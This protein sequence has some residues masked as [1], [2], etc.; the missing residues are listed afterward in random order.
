M[1]VGKNR[2][3]NKVNGKIRCILISYTIIVLAIVPSFV[4]SIS[5]GALPKTDEVGVSPGGTAKFEI[6]FYDRQETSL[7]F[8]LSLKEYPEE[9][10]IIY[11]EIFTSNSEDMEEE[12]VLISGEYIKGKLAEID[13]SVPSGTVPG[14]YKILLNVISSERQNDGEG[15]NGVLNINAEKTFLLKVNVMGHD[16]YDG[17]VDT[18]EETFPV[19]TG[20]SEI[21]PEI[22]TS[23][24]GEASQNTE[25]VERRKSPLGGL[26]TYLYE[27]KTPLISILVIV[28]ISVLI[29]S[30]PTK[31]KDK[32]NNENIITNGTVA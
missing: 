17:T 21:N 20:K 7:E 16:V 28:A 3:K 12:Y 27:N 6:L 22:P 1:L 5:F 30:Y 14:Q 4:F 11:P 23:E 9:F 26:F 10:N 13:V 29:V 18:T 15:W 2:D 19:E 8:R 32:F 31:N 25:D 24:V